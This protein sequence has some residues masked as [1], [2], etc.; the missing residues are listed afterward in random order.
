MHQIADSERGAHREDAEQDSEPFH[1]HSPFQGIHG[2]SQHFALR[3][4]DAVFDG[5]QSFGILGRDAQHAGQPAPQDSARA[6]DEDRSAHTD[7]VAGA[8]GGGQCGGQILELADIA[9]SIR[10]LGEG[11]LDGGAELSLNETGSCCQE[12]VSAEQQDDH[13]DAPYLAVKPTYKVAKSF[14]RLHPFLYLL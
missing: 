4:T 10:I 13:G 12:Q 1:T 14:H 6:A 3:G 2:A 8:D 11:E 9:G 7:D 5:Q